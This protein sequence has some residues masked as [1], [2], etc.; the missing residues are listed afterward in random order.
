MTATGQ[1]KMLGNRMDFDYSQGA[2]GYVLVL[3]RLI[4]GYWFLHAGWGKLTGPEAFDA[5]GW[6]I[7]ATGGSPIHGFLLWAGQ[8]PWMLEFTN[9]M[10]P[11]GEF[12]IGLGLLVGAL[13]RLAAFFGGLLMVFFYLGNADWGHGLVNGDLFGLMMFVIVG[14][15]AAGRIY[16]LDAIIEKTEFVRQH[17]A[18]KYLLG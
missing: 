8:T 3:T 1:I 11:A 5:G 6:L 9:F 4:T 17:P 7:N 12:L 18:L 10:I 2:T 16:G 15:L 14:T 13:T